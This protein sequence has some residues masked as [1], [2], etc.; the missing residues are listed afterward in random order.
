MIKK[1]TTR[2]ALLI[3]SFAF[4]F[5][6]VTRDLKHFVKGW[7]YNIDERN[8]WRKLRDRRLCPVYISVFGII[9]VMPRIRPVLGWDFEG[10]IPYLMKR[11][12]TLP[13]EVDYCA[14]WN[15]FGFLPNVDEPVLIDYGAN[16]TSTEH[17]SDCD[18]DCIKAKCKLED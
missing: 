9:N 14:Q 12:D 13:F 4:K 2:M 17:C 7:L 10:K 5:P 8:R 15:N 3:G 6:I 16:R 11:F 18:G 1:G